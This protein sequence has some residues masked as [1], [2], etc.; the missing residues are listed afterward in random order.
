M[1]NP[2]LY[3]RCIDQAYHHLTVTRSSA[4]TLFV[5]S[6]SPNFELW[7]KKI[8]NKDKIVIFM[9]NTEFRWKACLVVCR[10]YT[11]WETHLFFSS[12][13]LL[14][15]VMFAFSLSFFLFPVGVCLNNALRILSFVMTE[16]SSPALL[17]LKRTYFDY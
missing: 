15:L 6:A 8:S 4:Y 17:N 10:C 2:V 14:S 7:K 3:R 11:P 12:S 13:T 5:L 1:T 9:M 16:H